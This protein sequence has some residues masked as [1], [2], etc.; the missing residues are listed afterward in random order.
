MIFLASQLNK[1]AGQFQPRFLLAC[2][3]TGFSPTV[4]YASSSQLQL[5]NFYRAMGGNYRDLGDRG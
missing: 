4:I 1:A 2:L 3:S 5:V